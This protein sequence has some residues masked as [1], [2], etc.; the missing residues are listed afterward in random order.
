MH[1][2]LEKL[3]ILPSTFANMGRAE[4]ALV[5]ASIQLRVQAEQKAM[6]KQ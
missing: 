2:A 4:R 6:E 5:I 3:H 1:Y